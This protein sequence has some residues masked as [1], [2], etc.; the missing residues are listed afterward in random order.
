MSGAAC[1]GHSRDIQIV[2]GNVASSMTEQC[3]SSLYAQNARLERA[4]SLVP[5]GAAARLFFCLCFLL[6]S[7]SDLILRSQIVTTLRDDYEER[8]KENPRH[9]CSPFFFI[10]CTL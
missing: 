5:C 2:R 10:R 3:V 4:K 1:A 7:G 6:R 8:L 9:F